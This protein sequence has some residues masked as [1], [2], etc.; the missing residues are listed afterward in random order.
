M[1]TGFVTS[2]VSLIVILCLDGL[3]TGSVVAL[4]APLLVDSYPP[5]ARVRALSAYT[6]IGTFGQALAP[7]LVAVLASV[8]DLTWRGVFLALGVTS[9]LMT[10]CAIGLRDPGFGK[11]DTEQ[12]RASVHDEHGEAAA[13]ATWPPRTSRSGSGRSAAGCS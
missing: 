9:I 2:L 7:L 10:L 4:H 11:W 5:A 6:A 8:A 3:A 1:T 13:D 12:L